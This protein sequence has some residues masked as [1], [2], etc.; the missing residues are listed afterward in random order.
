MVLS[1][2]RICSS[3]TNDNKHV[4]GGACRQCKRTK[5]RKAGEKQSE[6]WWESMYTSGAIKRLARLTAPWLLERLKVWVDVLKMLDEKISQAK[7][8][9]A[10]SCN[11]PRPKGVGALSQM[12][13]QSEVLDWSLYSSRRKN[14]LSGRDGAQRMEYV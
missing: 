2:Y 5:E 6:C 7:A 3:L 13:L 12:P 4:K 10:R 14:R 1:G 11:G 8:A 9:F